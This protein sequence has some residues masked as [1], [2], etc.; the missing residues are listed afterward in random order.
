MAT[1]TK[2]KGTPF[3]MNIPNKAEYVGVARLAVSGIATRL[4]FSIEEIDDIKIAMSEAITNAVQYA[5]DEKE[6]RI[7]IT[8]TSYPK[9]LE[10]VVQDQGKGFDLNKKAPSKTPKSKL[11]MGLGLTFMKNLMDEADVTSKIGKGTTIRLVK[12]KK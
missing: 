3:I 8:C 4:N 1:T 12:K 2:T 6:G 5:Y 11:G 7:E 10:I 9:K